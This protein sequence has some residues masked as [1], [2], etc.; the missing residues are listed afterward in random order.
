[1]CEI[2]VAFGTVGQHNTVNIKTN[3]QKETSALTE[4]W[5]AHTAVL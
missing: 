1:M 3:E 2:N 5:E 4:R